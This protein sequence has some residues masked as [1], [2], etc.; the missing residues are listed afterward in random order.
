MME[1]YRYRIL[2]VDDDEGMLMLLRQKLK[3]A[4]FEIITCRDSMDALTILK[5]KDNI[6]LIIC[7]I[8]MPQMDG[9][10]FRQR[11]LDNPHSRDIPFIF[12]TAKADPADQVK[13]FKMRVDDY[14]T[15]PFQSDVLLARVMSVIERHEAYKEMVI[16]DPL[17]GLLN[18]KAIEER[19]NN[20]LKRI[21]RYNEFCSIVFI[22]IDDFK[23]VNDR[24]GHERGDKVLIELAVF[25]RRELRNTDYTGRYGGEE[26][27]V[28]L[29]NT[30]KT[31]ALRVAERLLSLFR[32]ISIGEEGIRCTFSA[33]I[34]SAPEDGMEFDE[35]CRKA[36]E[37][38]YV[39]KKNGKNQVTAWQEDEEQNL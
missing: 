27:V 4:G 21:Q 28:C 17:T 25:L 36:D 9:Y 7:D 11:T 2:V 18:R 15:K 16:T 34:A 14:I 30:G 24:Y 13:G 8:M 23:Q 10:E 19:I 20:E 31:L 33:G 35:L 38:M 5:E 32:E 1:D 26:F 29:V 22:D 3:K 12:L 6:D 37:A 39:S